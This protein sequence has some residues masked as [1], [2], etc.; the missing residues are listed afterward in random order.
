MEFDAALDTVKKYLHISLDNE[1][2]GI[3]VKKMAKSNLIGEE[4]STG[5]QTHIAITG[6]QRDAFP[7][8]CAAQYLTCPHEDI[9]DTIKRFF[10][11]QVKVNIYRSN[12]EPLDKSNTIRFGAGQEKKSVYT[13]VW[14]RRGK[15]NEEQVQ[16]SA[17]N[18]D[19]SDFVEFRKLI[20]TND[21]IVILKLQA[22][23]EYDWFI[24]PKESI[25]ISDDL[26]ALD[27]KFIHKSTSTVVKIDQNVHMDALL[28]NETTKGIIPSSN[29]LLY[30][31]PGCGKSHKVED[32]YESKITTE[33]NKIRV[34]FH[35]DYTY[36]DFVG[37]LLPVLKE[38]ENAQGVKE[39]K[40]QYE[41]VLGP[42]TQI[43]KTAYANSD[44]QC[45][46]IIE[47]L[48]RGNAPAI[49]GEIF[50]LLDRNDDGKSKYSIYNRDI[51]MA[52]YDEPNKPIELPP[53]LTIVATMITSDQNVFTMDTAFQRR[54]QM[55]HIPNRFTGE[56][57]DEKT[58]NHVAKHL[59]NSEISWGVFAQTIN[60]KMH[61][62]N[63]GFGGTED[64]SLGVYF[65]TD[66]DLDDAERF[67][68]KVLKYLWDDAFKLGRKELFNDCS[69][70]L[71]TVI[72]AYEDAA[73]A[74]IEK[75]SAEDPLKKVLVPAVYDE[76][77]KKM[78]EMAAEAQA[79]AAKEVSE[80]EAAESAAEDNPAQKPA[81]E[82]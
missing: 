72:E 4:N 21:Y 34:V 41:F 65:A 62:A 12:V 37:Q 68:E 7:Y 33:K 76:M 14:R 16:L 25:A 26:K 67:A 18:L 56:S 15:N 30:G 11:C 17:L 57:L 78:A 20:H 36:S 77:Q 52:L 39:E 1:Y 60:K 19:D 10:M 40:L 69:Q 54:W 63:L 70:G 45:L 55:K 53:N 28:H 42:F 81:G 6:A 35:P 59:P 82:E 22:C 47:E 27:G 74:K 3:I 66:N 31:V 71:S 43:L 29:I 38:V 23:L 48:N 8:I 75:Q 24:I 58:I 61:T 46:L 9:D 79:K 32:E 5:N 50:Q 49:F 13:T 51:S 2:D 64:K 73:K 80:E 44:Q